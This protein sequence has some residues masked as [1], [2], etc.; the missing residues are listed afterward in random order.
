MP[1][2]FQ[3]ISIIHVCDLKLHCLTLQD[4]YEMMVESQG[5]LLLPEAAAAAEVP[6]ASELQR[7]AYQR[8]PH[9]TRAAAGLLQEAFQQLQVGCVLCVCVVCLCRRAE[10]QNESN[11]QTNYLAIFHQADHII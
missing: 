10:R 4:E 8:L 7:T 5:E 1:H 9:R 6:V 2:S 3:T 11:D